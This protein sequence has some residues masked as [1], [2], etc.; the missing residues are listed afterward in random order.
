M[1][2]IFSLSSTASDVSTLF[3]SNISGVWGNGRIQFVLCPLS[4]EVQMWCSER[5]RDQPTRSRA[6]VLEEITAIPCQG[7]VI[8]YS[9]QG[10]RVGS[11]F[12]LRPTEQEESIRVRLTGSPQFHLMKQDAD[13]VGHSG[14]I[15]ETNLGIVGILGVRGIFG[16]NWESPKN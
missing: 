9:A 3:Q 2:I 11:C 14:K 13:V 6:F 15:L 1:H 7:R 16:K 4:N 12:I 8:L 10:G 5:T